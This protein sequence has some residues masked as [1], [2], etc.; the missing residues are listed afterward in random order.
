ML[1]Y[2]LNRLLLMVPTLVATAAL[3]FFVLRVIPGDIVEIKLT[4][5][6]GNVSQAALE[7][8]RQGLRTSS[9][10]HDAAPSIW[11]SENR[12]RGWAAP[13]P[14]VRTAAAQARREGLSSR[15]SKRIA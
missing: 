11:G 14:T 9:S 15:G 4:A 5:E 6:G 8:E 2:A 10:V 7:T 13:L 3:I 1:R 12:R